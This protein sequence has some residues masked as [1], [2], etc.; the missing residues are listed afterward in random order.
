MLRGA[1]P[2]PEEEKLMR[3]TRISIVAVI[4]ALSVALAIAQA[5]ARHAGGAKR[6]AVNA[7]RLGILDTGQGYY[8][9]HYGSPTYPSYWYGPATGVY[10]VDPSLCYAPRAHPFIGQWWRWGME[11]IC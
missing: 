3:W 6:A 9:P 5:E 7:W 2:R 10:A 4:G 8:Y 1:A 11:Y